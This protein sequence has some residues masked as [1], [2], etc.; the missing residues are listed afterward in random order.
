ML[1]AVSLTLNHFEVTHFAD[2]PS[3]KPCSLVI[4]LPRYNR[5]HLLPR[6]PRAPTYTRPPTS[7]QTMPTPSK[8]P[9]GAISSSSS[10]SLSPADAHPITQDQPLP[11]NGQFPRDA[12]L[13]HGAPLPSQRVELLALPV[14]C[15]SFSCKGG[16]TPVLYLFGDCFYCSGCW[17][18]EKDLMENM[19]HGLKQRWDEE[20]C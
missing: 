1:K 14:Q 9:R 4:P 16:S 7:R 3:V 5:H 19:Y 13:P 11:H 20:A 6:A 18:A 15:E 17:E 10:S 12:P 8:T 2:R